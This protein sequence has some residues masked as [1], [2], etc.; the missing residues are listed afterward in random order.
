VNSETDDPRDAGSPEDRESEED[1]LRALAAGDEGA[2]QALFDR[3][4]EALRRRV[5]GWLPAAVKRKVSVADVVQEVNLVALRRFP[6]FEDRGDGAFRA[7]LL[8]IAQLKAKAAVRRHVGAAKRTALREVSRPHRLGTG[9]YAVEGP[10]PSEAAIASERAELVRRALAELP[11]DY[12]EIL[13]LTRERQLTLREAAER[14]GRPRERVKKLYGRAV[15][16]FAKVF[17]R[18]EGGGNG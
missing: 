11:E 13:R 7:W 12:R 3:H 5:G 1:L 16:R 14:M 9:E 6:E 10:S 18:L 2:F 15:D 17:R 4:T 8:R